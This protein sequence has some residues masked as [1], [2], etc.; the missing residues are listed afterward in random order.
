MD[1]ELETR[2]KHVPIPSELFD[3]H[4]H[5]VNITRRQISILCYKLIY[6]ENP[7]CF[8][9][10][11]KER[12]VES[13]REFYPVHFSRVLDPKTNLSE[14]DYLFRRMESYAA[15][16]YYIRSNL[17]FLKESLNA[18]GYENISVGFLAGYNKNYK[19]VKQ[20][21]PH[22]Y[23]CD[24]NFTYLTLAEVHKMQSEQVT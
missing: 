4:V 18:V 5:G 2:I 21:R 23:G 22:G 7:G 24:V 6:H 8:P 1:I 13:L 20:V 12:T 3:S 11:K 10:S 15:K 9:F 14:V 16:H 17:K 19:Q